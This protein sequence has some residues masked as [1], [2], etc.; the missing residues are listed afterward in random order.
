[1]EF[2]SSTMFEAFEKCPYL[3]KDIFIINKGEEI[4]NKWARTGQELHNLFDKWAHIEKKDSELMKAEYAE[5]FD[6]I[7]KDL[8]DDELDRDAFLKQGYMTI[9]NWIVEEQT[10]PRPL[11][12]EQKFFTKLHPDLPPIRATI[13][14]INGNKDDVVNW[15][16]EDYKTGKIYPSNKLRSIIQLPVYAMTIRENFGALPRRLI[17]R[18]PLH[19]AERVF[20]RITDDLYTCRVKRGGTYNVSLAETLNKMVDIYKNIQRD[21]FMPNT[22]DTHFCENY[23]PLYKKQKCKALLTHW[24][25]LTKR[26]Y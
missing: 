15:D 7:D 3:F 4:P 10:R 1:M 26:G 6:S 16:V 21:T 9:L 5:M 11:M 19:Q 14:R 17:L 18:F 23:C 8:F 25:M 22:N 20:E 13:D 12:T 24:Q 2:V